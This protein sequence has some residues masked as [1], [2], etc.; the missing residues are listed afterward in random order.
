MGRA[1]KARRRVLLAG[2][3]GEEKQHCQRRYN[4]DRMPV[5]L[6][7]GALSCVTSVQP[8]NLLNFKGYKI[9]GA[10]VLSV[11]LFGQLRLLGETGFH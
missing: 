8:L 3:Y 1:G 5:Y 2:A 11:S 4:G 9:L 10:T 6:W 7:N